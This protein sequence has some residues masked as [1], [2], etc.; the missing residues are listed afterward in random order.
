MAV[1]QTLPSAREIFENINIGKR[2]LVKFL[3]SFVNCHFVYFRTDGK[4]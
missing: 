3:F 2:F 4:W 1:L